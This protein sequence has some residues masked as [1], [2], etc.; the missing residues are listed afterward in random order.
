MTMD[1]AALAREIS[2]LIA[3]Q[4]LLA[5]QP[6]QPQP[7]PTPTP[8]PP[9]PKPKKS[10]KKLREFPKQCKMWGDQEAEIK[11]S[12]GG[13]SRKDVKATY[14]VYSPQYATSSLACADKFWA[15]PDHAKK[16]LKYPWTAYCMGG[17]PG[18][19]KFTQDVCG[20]CLRVTNPRTGASIVVRAV[21]NGGC[22]DKD[23]TGL[24]L[25]VCAFN[26]LDIDGKGFNAG[27]M[28]VD[29]REVEC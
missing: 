12:V 17:L 13:I 19:K 27:H 15:D 16:L 8:P 29:V 11:D 24:D 18:G 3:T 20:K 26:A 1:I 23:G 22:S 5:P 7:T 2:R 9:P 21:D 28:R 25:D 6:P 14:H 4:P 10:N